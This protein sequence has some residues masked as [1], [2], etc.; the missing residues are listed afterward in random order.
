MID[1]ATAFRIAWFLAGRLPEPVVR[2]AAVTAA[3][4][5]WL[6]RPKDVRRLES[7]LARVRPD[8]TPKQIRRLTRA[9]MRSYLRYYADVFRMPRITD[10]QVLARCRAINIERILE[11]L[12]A[13]QSVVCA[14]GHVGNWD[15]AGRFAGLA[16]G[17]V[18]TV[19]ER[20]E[21]AELFDQYVKFREELGMRILAFGDDGVVRSLIKTLR[22]PGNVVPL[23]MD[24]D[25]SASGVE[26]EMFG[27]GVKMAP[28]PAVLAL[29]A[30]A[31]LIPVTLYH[32]RLRGAKRR[33]AGSPW[34]MVVK[35]HEPVPVPA[36]S[37]A[38]QVQQMIQASAD[39][40]AGTIERYPW[41]WHMLQRVFVAD[42]DP[43]YQRKATG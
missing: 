15:L 40:I 35:F 12:A 20:V 34:G 8:A 24:R 30:N 25:L 32:E 19:A 29:G 26:V 2:A 6:R 23:L 41:E 21:P 13:G 1:V 11:P 5:A 4:F 38:E 43:N 36:G 14:L 39:A 3:D 33:A 28:G 10:E 17:P 18:T 42:L 7:N 22:G 27:H 9:G 37:R 31:P 16:L